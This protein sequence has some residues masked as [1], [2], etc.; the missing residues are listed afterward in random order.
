[1]VTTVS[2]WG[3]IHQG[4]TIKDIFQNCN[5]KKG[6]KLNYFSQPSVL[7]TLIK[8]L[9]LAT[10]CS[11]DSALIEG[12]WLSNST[13]D[14]GTTLRHGL[15]VCCQDTEYLVLC[16]NYAQCLMWLSMLGLVP[17]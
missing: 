11:F 1:M 12:D 15:Y 9:I 16:S 14:H 13:S 10:G 4:V 6:Q 7:L 8:I 2:L 3:S 5:C 17:A